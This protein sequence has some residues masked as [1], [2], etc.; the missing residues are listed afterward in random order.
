MRIV[1][2][3]EFLQLPEGTVYAKYAPI[4][5]E[6]LCIKN[7]N[8]GNNDWDSQSLD[9]ISLVDNCGSEEL[10]DIMDKALDGSPFKMD[11]NATCMDGLYN[12][13]Q[14]FIVYTKEEVGKLILM[15][16]NA[17]GINLGEL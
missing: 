14:L 17:A 11:T 7:G 12:K 8:V 5:T 10:Y 1:N 6:E 13:D 2:R 9:T 4:Y 3:Q 15:L 16:A